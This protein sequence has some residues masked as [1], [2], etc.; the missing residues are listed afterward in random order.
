MKGY[1]LINFGKFFIKSGIKITK[2]YIAWWRIPHLKL[3][4]LE[5][6]INH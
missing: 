3:Q 5:Y 2:Y 1:K 6:F 4:N